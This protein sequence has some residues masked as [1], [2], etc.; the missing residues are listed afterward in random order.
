MR[1]QREPRARVRDFDNYVAPSVCAAD[2]ACTHHVH[3]ISGVVRPFAPGCRPGGSWHVHSTC[4]INSLSLA[5]ALFSR[6]LLSLSLSLVRALSRDLLRAL[7]RCHMLGHKRPEA[8]LPDRT[9]YLPTFSHFLIVNKTSLSLSISLSLSLSLA[10]SLARSLSR[11]LSLSL[12][13]SLSLSLSL[14]RLAPIAGVSSRTLHV[15]VCT[16]LHGFMPSTKPARQVGGLIDSH[17]RVCAC[18]LPIR[19]INS[20]VDNLGQ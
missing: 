8:V 5:H 14:S 2:I 17:I 18:L 3:Q 16:C 20:Q 11:S 13:L 12:A 10:L 1:R 9:L 15:Y 7:S 4:I 19:S 6:S